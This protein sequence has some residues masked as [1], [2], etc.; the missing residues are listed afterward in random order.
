MAH[1]TELTLPVSVTSLVEIGRLLRELETINE[2]LLQLHLKDRGATAKL[3]KTTRLMDRLADENKLNLLHEADRQRL[4]TFLQSIKTQAPVLHI[5]FSA[6]PSESFLEKL[7]A[8]LRKEIHPAALVSVGLQPNIG[9][10]CIVRTTNR[11]FDFSLR[12]DFAAKRE[13]LKQ[14]LKPKEEQV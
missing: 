7:V 6:D 2:A 3:P 8:W 13:L 10:G 9:A 4:E 12:E 14:S 5:S 11:Y 1:S